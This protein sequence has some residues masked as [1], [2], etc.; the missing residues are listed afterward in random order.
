LFIANVN[1][2]VP[3][4]SSRIYSPLSSINDISFN[5]RAEHISELVNLK[6][7]NSKENDIKISAYK[8]KNSKEIEVIGMKKAPK[9]V[10]LRIHELFINK[11]EI[12]WGTDLKDWIGS[13]KFIEEQN[14]WFIYEDDSGVLDTMQIKLK[15]RSQKLQVI[16]KRPTGTLR[17]TYSYVIKD[18][19]KKLLVLDK[20]TR[21]TYEGNQ[22]I[23]TENSVEYKKLDS[24][25]WVPSLLKT[26]TTQR[27]NI[28]TINKIV[29]NL[30]EVFYFEDYKINKN[31]AKVWFSSRK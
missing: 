25:G 17:T 21:K 8:L 6:V 18:W 7:L 13:Y 19:S 5:V 9:N 2:R 4:I 22:S 10:Q 3:D 24:V 12:V 27:V 1:A 16:E 20:I 11:A 14:N 28:G 31:A 15:F 29:R 23:H 30:D 26:K